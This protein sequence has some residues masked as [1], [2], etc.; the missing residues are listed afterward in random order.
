LPT[1]A[2]PVILQGCDPQSADAVLIDRRLPGGELLGR[3]RVTLVR[4]LSADDAGADG[5]D[6]RGL[7]PSDPSVRIRR[8]QIEDAVALVLVYGHELTSAGCKA[9]FATRIIIFDPPI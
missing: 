9:S 8:R 6:H 7:T 3:E 4:L 5:E 1:E 2:S